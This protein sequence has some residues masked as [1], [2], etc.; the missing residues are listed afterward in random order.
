MMAVYVGCESRCVD[1][2]LAACAGPSCDVVHAGV[3]ECLFRFVRQ[4]VAR[5]CVCVCVCVFWGFRVRVAA[6]LS[7][8]RLACSR[9]PEER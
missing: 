4:P 9:D 5:V 2:R 1:W 8:T 6:S 3:S 7:T